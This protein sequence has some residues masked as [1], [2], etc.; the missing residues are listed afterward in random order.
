MDKR[1]TA[2]FERTAGI[3]VTKDLFVFETTRISLFMLF[4][5]CFV[6]TAIPGLIFDDIHLGYSSWENI[7]IL[8]TLP[9]L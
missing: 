8:K 7:E 3:Y 5:I 2:S 9:V 1:G 4:N 6:A